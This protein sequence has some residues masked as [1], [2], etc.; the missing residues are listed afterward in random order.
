MVRSILLVD[1]P[2]PA[3]DSLYRSL[4][5]L[6]Y[7]A[8]CVATSQAALDVA[9]SQPPDVLLVGLHLDQGTPHALVAQLK[10]SAQTNPL[11]VV[12]MVSA[13]EKP[14]LLAVQADAILGYPP[15]AF[16]LQDALTRAW[17][18]ADRR[19]LERVRHEL[20][21]QLQS[22][23]AA[24]DALEA[25]FGHW[26]QQAGLSAH[27]VQQLALAVRE[28]VANAIEWGHGFRTDLLVK[29]I[30]RCDGEK[31]SVWIRDHGT[32]FNRHHLPH[33][34]RFGDP[35]SHLAVRAAA[36]LR[37]GGFGIL[38]ANGLVDH[39]AYNAYGNEV[40]LIKYLP[41]AGSPAHVRPVDSGRASASGGDL[42]SVAVG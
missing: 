38:M 24:L 39:L 3:R 40:L 12:Q 14:P 25:P 41:L 11:A 33:A 10:A 1:S 5:S 19:R 16:C 34:A 32:G 21:W 15:G 20:H 36:N 18:A 37:D 17:Q 13:T 26:A 31:V 8:S 27:G 7:S 9:S 6:G 35:V 4:L 30:A 29:I 28:L 23:F 22:T 2:S 42:G